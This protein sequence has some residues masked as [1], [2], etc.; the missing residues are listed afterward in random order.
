M[1]KHKHI[2]FKAFALLLS[3]FMAQATAQAQCT[4]P[5]GI[6]VNTSPA[7]CLGE[8]KVTVSNIQG[9]TSGDT[10]QY[11]LRYDSAG[12]TSVVKPWQS[13]SIFTQV[14]V[15]KYKVEVRKICTSSISGE[16]TEPNIIVS[17]NTTPLFIQSIQ[18]TDGNCLSPTGSLTIN[19]I[20]GNTNAAYRYALVPSLNAPEPTTY[21][22]P[23]QVSNTFSNLG[24]GTYYIRVYDTCEAYSTAQSTV[25]VS[26]ESGSVTINPFQFYCDS[27]Q[28][29][30]SAFKSPASS[31][32]QI[33]SI[34]RFWITI[35]GVTDTLTPAP[36]QQFT[37]N[38]P[39]NSISFSRFYS[40]ISYPA[41]ITCGFKTQCGNVY[42]SSNNIGSTPNLSVQAIS[43][44]GNCSQRNY[45]VNVGASAGA[46]NYHNT[47]Y[48]L[49][50]GATWS[51]VQTA[52]SYSIG[53]FSTNTTHT[54][55][56]A[57]D[58]DTATTTFTP[59]ANQPFTSSAVLNNQ[60]SC[61]TVNYSINNSV[62][63]TRYSLNNGVTWSALQSSGSYSI[64]D[65]NI[66]A[67]Q[68]VK[69]ARDCDTNTL[70]FT[71]Q[72]GNMTLSF[73]SSTLPPCSGN[74]ALSLSISGTPYQ[75]DSTL[76]RV[77]NQ[78]ATAQLPDSFY[79][80]QL[81]SG[82][83]VS[84]YNTAPGSYIISATDY[85]HQNVDTISPTLNALVNSIGTITP[86][87]SCNPTNTG[88][89][90]P[91]SKSA[92][93]ILSEIKVIV[94][95]VATGISDTSQTTL[96][97]GNGTAA[98]PNRPNGSY[99]IK[100]LPIQPNGYPT[101]TCV[102]SKTYE[103]T[104]G[105]PLS[106]QQST[107]TSSCTNGTA[108]VAA[109][110]TG[111]GGGYQYS[112]DI[113]GTGGAWSSVAGP[114][115]SPIFNGLLV[116]NVY[117]VRAVDTCGNGTLYSTSFSNA[118]V[119]LNYSS[120][121][122]PCPGQSFTMSVPQSNLATYSWQKNHQS[123]S[124]ATNAAYTINTVQASG[125]D[126][127]SVQ[128]NYGTCAVLSNI[129]VVD[130]TACGAPLP[131]HLRS[132]NGYL[133]TMGNAVLQWELSDVDDVRHFELEYSNDARNFTK[134]ASLKATDLT[135]YSY[136]DSKRNSASLYYR[137]KIAGKDAV[138]VY[139]E[140]IR[141]NRKETKERNVLIYPTVFSEQ[142]QIQYN[143]NI[144]EQLDWSI[145]NIQGTVKQS[146][147]LDMKR[148]TTLTALNVSATLPE[149]IYM[150]ILKN[151][152]GFS[153]TQKVLY[154]K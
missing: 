50:N 28:I 31:N 37:Q 108:T 135:G 126:T 147:S 65:F 29:S 16:F 117:R 25:T 21:V 84:S 5:T 103:H 78:P 12:N 11:Q 33:G 68:Q 120:S 99:I 46:S 27:L 83:I 81:N 60:S 41:N 149:G 100:L 82:I 32:V 145:V 45:S 74:S 130:P 14:A 131:I 96:F 151:K 61:T 57:S 95:N 9:G 113:Q 93:S 112:L 90:V 143:T 138:D 4:T 119:P 23:K 125:V 22:A 86:I 80:W 6:T 39:T 110:A 69:V 97:M 92:S 132:F 10:Y 51:S 38:T 123:I 15:A 141:L 34:E 128:I 66:G 18:T 56:V 140:I 8:G 124:G 64:G 98:F 88:F 2:Y 152:T 47:R 17:G 19:A 122:A 127:Y 115:A 30:F 36:G 20:G 142:L 118:P 77:I 40:G 109:L 26:T 48:S 129:F 7:L 105:Q 146:G 106:L 107:F 134:I 87:Y 13:D 58:C 49:N 24:A 154:R 102:V 43:N 101:P 91:V 72:A 42:Q 55:M 75:I 94:T 67:T 136:T 62:V 121:V 153:Y 148:G 52:G 144:D 150:L 79:Y 44:G 54:V 137:L 76:F 63:N 53:T 111:G 116:N 35:N 139:S 70:S 114:Q 133:N 85:C 3:L 59:P 89:K 104:A 1:T 71:P 73:S